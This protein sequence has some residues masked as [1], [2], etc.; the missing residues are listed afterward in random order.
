MAAGHKASVDYALV[1]D[2]SIIIIHYF[3]SLSI[4]HRRGPMSMHET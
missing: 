3:I 2:I 1:K 4:P